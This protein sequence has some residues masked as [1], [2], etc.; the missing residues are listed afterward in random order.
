MKSALRTL[1]TDVEG[2]LFD[3]DGP[4]CHLFAPNGAERVAEQL[5]EFV[6]RE[7]LPAVR[8]E[9]EHS[10]LDVLREAARTWPDFADVA[11]LEGELTSLEEECAEDALMTPGVEVLVQAI[12]S[13]GIPVAITT[14]NSEKAVRTCLA[15]CRLGP[16]F[17]THVY[18]RR[19]MAEGHPLL[20][21][22]D[23]ACIERAIGELRLARPECCLMIGDSP[24]DLLAANSAD[25]RFLGFENPHVDDNQELRQVF[26]GTIVE[27]LD[28]IRAEFM[29]DGGRVRPAAR[30]TDRGYFVLESGPQ[31]NI[32][33][34][35]RPV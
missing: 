10:P 23:P 7:R 20:L 2:V 1:L 5:H 17:G 19:S 35:S 31:R 28:D 16:L 13:A 3:F 9:K 30:P 25:V 22:P 14:N 21:M 34:V 24:A 18:G 32:Y 12:R 27:R 29:A 26:P 8:P 11:R 15:N 6:D 4:L 33:S